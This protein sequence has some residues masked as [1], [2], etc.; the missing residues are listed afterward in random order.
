MNEPPGSMIPG[1]P[2][3]EDSVDSVRSQ[4]SPPEKN[5][6]H[7]LRRLLACNPFYLVSVGLLLYGCYRISIEPKVFNDESAHLFFNFGSLQVYELLLAGT[8]IFLARR[9]IWYD[10][11]L[12]VGLENLL[13]LAPFILISQA[14]LID[15][16]MLW[17]MCGVAGV[18]A[19]IRLTSVKAF[20]TKLNF[21]P[22]LLAIGWLVLL[23]NVLL[24]AV[25]RILH[26]S[27]VGTH[28]EAGAAWQ[29]NECVW[30]ILFPALC[31]LGALLPPSPPLGEL[32]PQ[33]RWLPLGLFGLWV[34]GTGVHLYCLGYVYDF[35][36]RAELLAPA[37]WVLLWMADLRINDIV[38]VINPAW[39]RVLIVVPLVAT[40]AA[41]TPAGSKVFLTLTLLNA[42]I[43]GSIFFYYRDQR[44]ALHLLLISF[45]AMVSGLPENWGAGLLPGFTRATAIAEAFAAYCLLCVLA[46]RNP[47]LG[48]LGALIVAGVVFRALGAGPNTLHWALQ[49]GL[50]FLLLHSLRWFDPEYA[51]AKAVRFIAAIGWMAHALAWMHLGGAAWM[52]CSA[53]AFVLAIYL[54]A[55][56][57]EGKWG[58][59]IVP[60]AAAVVMLSGPS[61]FTLGKVH[62]IPIGLA[63]VAGSFLLFGIG[64]VAALTR[65]RW[66]RAE[67][68]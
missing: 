16:R 42:A 14:G 7:V 6:W 20:I 12:L 31:G 47:K 41:W 25:Y 18:L 4:A 23:S 5:H 33:R 43:Y 63:A 62:F 49:A 10:S 11:T 53:G 34:A 59:A 38:P 61:D 13:L 21:P 1:D 58:P 67:K 8:A 57:I 50:M 28:L 66:H 19:M 3:P 2:K 45:A 17:V 44:I 51:G 65:H 36:L 15:R 39:H 37:I 35:N 55:R 64:T 40:F 27:K 48:V 29:T 9:R 26:E 54:V 46:S 60:M 68:Q 32:W 56:V 52:A 24:P 22:R 30:L